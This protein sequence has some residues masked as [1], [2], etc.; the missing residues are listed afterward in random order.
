MRCLRSLSSMHLV[1]VILLVI[2]QPVF[3]AYSSSTFSDEKVLSE[4]EP[5]PRIRLSVVTCIK[6]LHQKRKRAQEPHVLGLSYGIFDVLSI[7][8]PFG[9]H[10][11]VTL[12]ASLELSLECEGAS[13]TYAFRGGVDQVTLV[14]D[15]DMFPHS[16]YQVILPPSVRW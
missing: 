13:V 3:L 16:P 14:P 12:P 1:V 8:L 6:T 10:R 2:S 11:R 5:T 9:F 7:K 4:R 15:D